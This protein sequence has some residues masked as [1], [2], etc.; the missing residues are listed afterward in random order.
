LTNLTKERKNYFIKIKCHYICL[1]Y[2]KNGKSVY[3]GSRYFSENS[4]SRYIDSKVLKELKIMNNIAKNFDSLITITLSVLYN[5]FDSPTKLFSDL[6]LYGK[7]DLIDYCV[8]VS[9]YQKSQRYTTTF[10]FCLSIHAI[11]R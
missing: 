6:Y 5:Y 11:N 2:I 4:Q 3:I 9:S 8:P 7:S 1:N 10:F